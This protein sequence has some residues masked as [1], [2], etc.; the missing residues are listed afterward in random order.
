VVD[1]GRFTYAEGEPN[2]RRWFKGTAAHNTVTV[3]GRD[4]TPYARGKPKG[5][6]AE[7]RPGARTTRTGIDVLRGEVR[8]P[9]YDAVHARTIVFVD[10]AYWIVEDRLTG[11]AVHRYD[12]RFHLASPDARVDGAGRVVAPGLVLVVAGVDAVALQ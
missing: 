11:R 2:L 10:D 1:P 12:L 8:S 9:V 3:D 5:A 7:A 4:Q 6:T